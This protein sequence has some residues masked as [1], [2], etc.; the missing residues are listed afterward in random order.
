MAS[1]RLDAKRN[2]QT[3]IQ[4][5]IDHVQQVGAAESASVFV[6]GSIAIFECVSKGLLG[7]RS[8]VT[9]KPC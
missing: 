7:Q 6:V 1:S 5:W 4:I 8:R 2:G 3:G 9:Y